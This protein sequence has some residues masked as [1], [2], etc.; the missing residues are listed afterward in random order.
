[1]KFY[2][3][4][5][6]FLINFSC[7][8]NAQNN[9]VTKEESIKIDSLYQL[10]SYSYTVLNAEITSSCYLENAVSIAHYE[11]KKPFILN[12][13][14]AILND[15]KDFFNSIKDNKQTMT[16]VFKIIDRQL[17]NGKIFDIGY[18][19]VSFLKDGKEIDKSYGKV[20]IILAKNAENKWKYETDTNSTCS[21]LEFNKAIIITY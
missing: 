5:F 4:F 15:F 14:K 8:L 7:V 13:N 2:T 18:Y 19:K 11:N 17:I 12:G 10:F 3:F 20:A 21:E 1:M 6:S 16:I 9:T